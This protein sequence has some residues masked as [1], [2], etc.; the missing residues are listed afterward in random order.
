[1]VFSCGDIQ[2][3]CTMYIKQLELAGIWWEQVEK[4]K[5]FAI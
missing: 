4:S 2:A 5:R 3:T 1:M